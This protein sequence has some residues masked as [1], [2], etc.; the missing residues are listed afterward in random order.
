MLV[1]LRLAQK[2]TTNACRVDDGQPK[3]RR[4]LT[5]DGDD[6]LAA[7]F[8]LTASE[9]ALGTGVARVWSND[10]AGLT[11]CVLACIHHTTG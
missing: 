10:V 2:G 8:H 9:Q 4:P 1:L 6:I 5:C 11:D 3:V 7:P